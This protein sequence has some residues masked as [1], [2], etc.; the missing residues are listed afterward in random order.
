MT[1]KGPLPHF[2]PHTS[3]LTVRLIETDVGRIT[4][5]ISCLEELRES[6][7]PHALTFRRGA[8]ALTRS[9]ASN[10]IVICHVC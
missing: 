5:A 3:I 8:V 4:S 6:A 2:T 9:H 1:K 10:T 7:V